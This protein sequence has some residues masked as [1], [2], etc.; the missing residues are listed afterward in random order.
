MVNDYEPSSVLV[1]L[2]LTALQAKVYLALLTQNFVTAKTISALSRVSRPDVYRIIAQLEEL[3]L[4]ERIIGKPTKYQATPLEA[5]TSILMQNKMKDL[6]EIKKRIPLLIQQVGERASEK[7]KDP[8]EFTISI[9]PKE[10]FYIRSKKILKNVKKTIR[11]II[12]TE[13]VVLPPDEYNAIL[14]DALSRN[15]D[16]KV[17]ICYPS[18]EKLRNEIRKHV[19]PYENYQV[20]FV[21][22]TPI[23]A[24][25]IF[26]SE[27]VVINTTPAENFDSAAFWS[28]NKNIINLCEFYF[29]S[30]WKEGFV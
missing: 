22:E 20:R 17:I 10:T 24:M 3:Q 27:E 6:A 30:L 5:S 9:I 28:S 4:V 8:D 25:G 16:C 13:K 11:S 18:N 21:K 14:N 29:N 2:G 15:V 19:S 23:T 7:R 26:D 1:D 12:A